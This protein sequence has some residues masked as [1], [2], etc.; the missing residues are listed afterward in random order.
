MNA[1]EYDDPAIWNALKSGHL[2]VAKLNVPFSHLLTDHTTEHET[3]A[4]TR[5]SGMVGMSDN[6]ISQDQRSTI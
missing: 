6:F 3:K 1:L 5:Q 4:L 2:A